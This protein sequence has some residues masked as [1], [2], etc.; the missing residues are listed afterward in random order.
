MILGATKTLKSLYGQVNL[1]IPSGT[2][3]DAILRVSGY[4]LPNMRNSN[5]KGDMYVMVKPKFPKQINVE[6]KSILELYKKTK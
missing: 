4:G 2:Q 3:P 5:T 6:Q 1:K